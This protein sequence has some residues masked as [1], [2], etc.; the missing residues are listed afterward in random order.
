MALKVTHQLP[1]LPPGRYELLIPYSAG[2]VEQQQRRINQE[3]IT[4]KSLA[5]A[6][7]L[8]VIILLLNVALSFSGFSVKYLTYQSFCFACFL[9]AFNILSSLPIF[10]SP[11]NIQI[12][13][14]GLRLHWLNSFFALSSPWISWDWIEHMGISDFRRFF[15]KSASIELQINSQEMPWKERIVFALL[16][17][18]LSSL[19]PSKL[20][21]DLAA[22]GAE[23]DATAL[24]NSI[25]NLVDSTKLGE[26]LKDYSHNKEAPSYTRLWLNSFNADSQ[27]DLK[28]LTSGDLLHDGRYEIIDKIAAGGQAVTYLAKT[29]ILTDAERALKLPPLVVL[30]EFILP[31]RGGTDIRRRALENIDHEAIM[32][33]QL[34]H[35]QIVKLLESFLDSQR[36]Y[37]VLE[38]IDGDS[39]RKL[40]LEAGPL[41]QEQVQD[42]ALEMCE[43]LSYLHNQEPPIIHRDFTP[44]NLLLGN[45]G[46][47]TLIDFNVAEQL[48][49]GNTKTVV[50]KHC[51]IPP[52]QFR[53]H[54]TI[55]SDIYGLGGTLF[56]LLTG[57][58]P[59]PITT[60]HPR[61]V[62]ANI[63]EAMD[64]IVARATSVAA[65]QRYSTVTEIQKD[66]E[67][68]E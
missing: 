29:N 14:E 33:S 55:Q 43:I 59:E 20:R 22:I 56:W 65:S 46:S 36:A 3:E 68:L 5:L 58:D 39:L 49:S 10:A 25:R 38:H 42:L 6:I 23:Q 62:V 51:Y 8:T 41:P 7:V 27:P 44:D 28:A 1:S 19:N 66:L 24:I 9:C 64:A 50:G 16:S 37:L 67:R 21:L 53:G 57:N 52:E 11:S 12:G 35:P 17:P 30:K 15:Y 61:A 48:E 18:I 34:N 63:S 60:S 32:L 45:D 2:R 54:P 40:T 13:K 47:L 4:S 26:E 31:V